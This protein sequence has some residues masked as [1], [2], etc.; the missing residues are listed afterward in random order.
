[1]LYK[2]IL[3]VQKSEDQTVEETIEAI[4]SALQAIT[5]SMIVTALA[6]RHADK[7][8][9]AQYIGYTPSEASD[10][11]IIRLVEVQRDPMEPPRFKINKEIRQAP[12]SPPPPVMHSPTRKVSVREQKEWRIPPC[13]YNWKNA[14][15]YTISLDK[16]V[17]AVGRRLQRVHIKARESVEDEGA[18]GEE[19][20]A[21]GAGEE[22]GSLETV[23]SMDARR[24]GRDQK[25]EDGGSAGETRVAPRET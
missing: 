14:K 12:A 21:E 15:G 18:D 8:G 17:D 6:V 11:R 5:Q 7:T 20:S 2:L 10:Q 23:G 22:R 4:R 1:M 9:S 3:D 13:V 24:E 25:R 19:G 16:R